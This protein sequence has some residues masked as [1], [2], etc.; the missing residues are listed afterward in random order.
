MANQLT[1]RSV[2]LSAWVFT[3]GCGG[4]SQLNTGQESPK[5]Q[6]AERATQ[7]QTNRPPSTLAD[8]KRSGIYRTTAGPRD[9]DGDDGLED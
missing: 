6:Q 9:G 7:N 2:V 4:S 8:A 1:K 3:L 5:S